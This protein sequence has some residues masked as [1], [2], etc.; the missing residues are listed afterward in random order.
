[1]YQFSSNWK[2]DVEIFAQAEIGF[3]LTR[4]TGRVVFEETKT[5]AVSHQ[6]T[7]CTCE[8]CVATAFRVEVV[9][10]LNSTEQNVRFCE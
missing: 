1:M 5:I 10:F 7:N 6:V 2:Q 4:A 3:T 9:H 8:V